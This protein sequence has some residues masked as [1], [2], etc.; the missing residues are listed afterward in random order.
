VSF[1]SWAGKR[2]TAGFRR[3]FIELAVLLTAELS[4]A[5]SFLFR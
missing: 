1:Y 5:A 4:I 2:M 3:A